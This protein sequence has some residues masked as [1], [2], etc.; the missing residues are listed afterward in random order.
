MKSI[1]IR[2][3]TLILQLIYQT[4]RRVLGTRRQIVCMSRQSDDEPIDFALIRAYIE[5]KH[6]GYQVIIMAKKITNPLTYIPHMLLQTV[7]IATS[8]AVLLDSYC[9]VVS[10]LGHTIEAP[11]VQLWHAMGNM[12]RFGYAALDEPEGRSTETAHLMHM[13]EGYDS[14]I[15]SSLC[16][17]DDYVAGFNVSPSIVFES[18]LPKA[19]LLLSRDYRAQRRSEIERRYP[20]LKGKKNIVYCPTFRKPTTERDILA[21]ER[22]ADCVDFDRYN[23]IYKPHPVSKLHFSDPRV[24]Q[25]YDRSFDMLYVADYV[26]SDYS[27]VIYESGLMGVPVLLYIYDWSSY[28]MRRGLNI[29]LKRDV[30]APASEDP[31]ELMARIEKND[32]DLVAYE[33][34]IKRYVVVPETGSCTGR[35]VRHVF[36]LISRQNR[37]DQIE[38]ALTEVAN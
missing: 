30:P 35:I 33:Y 29:D 14:V 24:F 38:G 19:D 27:S 26:I 16:F 20:L 11:V 34:F 5:Q 12:K 32:F 31:R 28:K 6:P 8:Q 1:A 17:I 22:L 18:P 3:A 13:H 21:L 36:S 9:I 25:D 4:A 2:C 37:E 10:L 15:I 23:L 7:R